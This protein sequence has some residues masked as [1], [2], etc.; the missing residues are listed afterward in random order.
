MVA[1]HNER[2]PMNSGSVRGLYS[3]FLTLNSVSTFL[4]VFRIDPAE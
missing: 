4:Q 1:A 3:K 2:G